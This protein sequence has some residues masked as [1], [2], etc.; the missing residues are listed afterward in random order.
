MRLQATLD[1]EEL[2]LRKALQNET[3]TN[4]IEKIK[5]ALDIFSKVRE[6]G[7]PGEPYLD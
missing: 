5:T 4:E 6:W 2:K 7:K 3:D 1:T